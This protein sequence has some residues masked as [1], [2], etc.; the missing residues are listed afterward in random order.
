M[1]GVDAATFAELDAQVLGPA[2][3]VPDG[4]AFHVNGP[5]DDG[6]YVM[7]AWTSKDIRD[8]FMAGQVVPAI[9]GKVVPEIQELSLHN[10][11][12]RER[13]TV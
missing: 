6:W 4:C 2:R 9:G 10:S 1:P 8:R 13:E 12:Q 5:T 11:I 7:D 3:E